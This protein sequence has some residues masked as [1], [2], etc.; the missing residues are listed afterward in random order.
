MFPWEITCELLVRQVI[1]QIIIKKFSFDK[2]IIKSQDLKRKEVLLHLLRETPFPVVTQHLFKECFECRPLSTLFWDAVKSCQILFLFFHFLLSKCWICFH[3]SGT[4]SPSLLRMLCATISL[5]AQVWRL[6]FL[7]AYSIALTTSLYSRL[8]SGSNYQDVTKRA[9][10]SCAPVLG[11]MV[12]LCKPYTRLNM[13]H[14]IND[15]RE[16][17]EHAHRAR[18]LPS[19]PPSSA[20]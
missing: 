5:Q 15:T 14:E 13:I 12:P 3:N 7:H 11:S 18:F 20:P 6:L 2:C 1:L 9:L 17:A 16:R 4:Q 19:G 8:R 10:V